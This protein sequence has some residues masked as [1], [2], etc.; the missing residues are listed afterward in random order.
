MTK[1]IIYPLRIKKR[2]KKDRRTKMI[3]FK[4]LEAANKTIKTTEIKG[5]DYAEV[6]QRIK[7]FRMIY[8]TGFIR[9]T[10]ESNEGGVCVFKAEVGYYEELNPVVLGIGH[11]FEKQD[12]TFIN[13]TSYIENCETS[14]VGRALGMAGFGIDVS[15]ASAEEVQNAIANQDKKAQKK[16]GVKTEEEMKATETQTIDGIALTAVKKAIESNGY[17]IEKICEFFK[18][19]KIEDMTVAQLRQFNDMIERDKKK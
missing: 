10:M 5:K 9:T 1:P 13:K 6:P 11:A 12:S 18:L 14:A 19:E 16:T 3:T 2:L 17:K 7:A 15:V 8:P 4:D